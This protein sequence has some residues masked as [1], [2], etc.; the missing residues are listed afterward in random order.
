MTTPPRV[1][2][3][4]LDANVLYGQFIRDVLLRLANAAFF[5]PRWTDRIQREW[6]ENLAANRPE[7]LDK[8]ERV[9]DLMEFRF[10]RAR[11]TGYRGIE[12]SL[13][14]V[15]PKDRH[16]A[17]AAIRAR[18]SHLVTF[19]LR[20]FPHEAL[21]PYSVVPIHP[22]DFVSELVVENGPTI[23][24]ALERHRLD[25]SRPSYTPAMYH[26]AFIRAGLERSAAL[27]P[28]PAD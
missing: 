1:P 8:I 28:A 27:L 19:N 13:T 18:A 16:V 7:L 10:P 24:A 2:I 5:Q 15:D 3:A 9:R 14:S 11:V 26:A 20:H 6:M 21:E 25:M 22:D 17:A 23:L 4:L 12:R